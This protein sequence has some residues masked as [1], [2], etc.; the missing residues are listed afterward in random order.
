MLADGSGFHSAVFTEIHRRGNR[1]ASENSIRT[2]FQRFGVGP[3]DFDRTWNSFEVAQKL[4]VAQDL[5]RRYG[6]S[7][8]PTMVVNGKYRTG[9]AEAGSYSNLLELL[10]EL[11]VRESLR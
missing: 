4:R 5:M 3:E 2:L 1:L 11:V 6:V 10:D 8:T 7:S 9:G